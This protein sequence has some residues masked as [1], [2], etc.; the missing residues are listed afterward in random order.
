MWLRLKTQSHN[1]LITILGFTLGIIIHVLSS[2]ALKYWLWPEICKIFE[3]TDFIWEILDEYK[4][5]QSK[6]Y[7]NTIANAFTS[8]E[9]SRVFTHLLFQIIPSQ[10]LKN[11]TFS[12]ELSSVPLLS[13]CCDNRLSLFHPC[14]EKYVLIA[15]KM[16]CISIMI[17]F[18]PYAPIV[19]V[20]SCYPPFITSWAAE[21]LN[22]PE[23]QGPIEEALQW[24]WEL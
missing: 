2:S 8:L 15:T 7:W 9:T 5:N 3:Q 16:F 18:I 24:L 17:I 19:Y 14:I 20:R 6:R 11:I 13:L 12:I 23:F 22:D 10:K 4:A 21:Y 1:I